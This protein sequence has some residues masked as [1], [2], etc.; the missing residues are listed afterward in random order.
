MGK[1]ENKQEQPANK[2]VLDELGKITKWYSLSMGEREKMAYDSFKLKYP[3]GTKILFIEMEITHWERE[4]NQF[5]N[6]HDN[7]QPFE[8]RFAVEA[9]K[10]LKYYSNKSKNKE[11]LG[12]IPAPVLAEFCRLLN[13]LRIMEKG[14]SETNQNFCIRVCKYFDFVYV[15]RVRQCFS[16]ISTKSNSRKVVEIVLPRID[17]STRKLLQENFNNKQSTKIK[18]YG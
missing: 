17:E 5:V 6:R 2:S 16:N 9:K 3:D 1:T 4:V 12:K 10:M 13:D 18:L 14:E 11:G 7:P 8:T 15:D